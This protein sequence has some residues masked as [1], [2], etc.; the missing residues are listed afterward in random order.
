MDVVSIT[1]GGGL[2]LAGLLI[3][4]VSIPLVRGWVPRNSLYGV[5]TPTTL[6]SDDAWFEINRY[7]GRQLIAW[8]I[9]LIVAGAT[10][11]FLPLQVHPVRAIVLGFSPLA[12][13][14]IP[15]VRIMMFA[16]RFS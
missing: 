8:A 7:G 2:T 15:I 5:R 11:F 3:I 14:A 13:L 12:I 4:A 10:C 16:R 9:P 6:K 1:I